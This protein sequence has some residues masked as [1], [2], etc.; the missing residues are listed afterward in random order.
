MTSDRET[1]TERRVLNRY[2]EVRQ[3]VLASAAFVDWRSGLHTFDVDGQTLFVRGGD[4]LR[5][6]DQVIF[7]WARR[8]G[9]LSDEAVASALVEP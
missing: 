2:P 3:A 1:T 9:L 7:E 6:E 4:M 5:D 8:N